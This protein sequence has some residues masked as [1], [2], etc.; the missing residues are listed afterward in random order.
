MNAEAGARFDW[1]VSPR[2]TLNAAVSGFTNPVYSNPTLTEAQRTSDAYYDRGDTGIL[3]EPPLPT[4]GKSAG[5]AMEPENVDY[6]LR[7][8]L[9]GTRV[10][11]DA[12]AG[13]TLQLGPQNGGG[14]GHHK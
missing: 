7:A 1:Q 3:S 10:S 6:Y 4:G 8:P 2:V 12:S 14:R 9:A 13:M 11:F 5:A